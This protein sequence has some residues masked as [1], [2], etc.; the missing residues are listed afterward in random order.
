MDYINDEIALKAKITTTRAKMNALWNQRGH[1]DADVLEVSIQLDHL[2]NQYHQKYMTKPELKAG[3]SSMTK[4][5]IFCNDLN[6]KL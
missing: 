1:T 5:N 6:N 3:K 4:F 2:I